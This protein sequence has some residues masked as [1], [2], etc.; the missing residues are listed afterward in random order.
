M[1]MT[2]THRVA[3]NAARSDFQ[4]PAPLDGVIETKD[5]R[6]GGG[7]RADQQDE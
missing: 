7:E 3:I 2:G 6:A 4:A 5:E 1:T